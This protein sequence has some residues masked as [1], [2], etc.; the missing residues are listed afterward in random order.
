M[1]SVRQSIIS[2]EPSESSHLLGTESFGSRYTNE[3]YRP[4]TPAEGIIQ[5]EWY[6]TLLSTLLE[7]WMNIRDTYDGPWRENFIRKLKAIVRCF[8]LPCCLLTRALNGRRRYFEPQTGVIYLY[9]YLGVTVVLNLVVALKIKNKNEISLAEYI[10]KYFVIFS[11]F[12][13]LILKFYLVVYRYETVTFKNSRGTILRFFNEGGTFI[14]G[15]FCFGYSVC[16]VIDYVSCGHALD[17]LVQVMKAIFTVLQ[18]LFLHFFYEAR[19]PEDSPY[20]QIILAHLLGTNLGIWFWT[21]C[22]DEAGKIL[23]AESCRDYPI[24]LENMDEYFA[25]LFVEYLLLAASLFYQIW[26]DLLPQFT[27]VSLPQRHCSTCSCTSMTENANNQSETEDGNANSVIASAAT[28]TRSRSHNSSSG[29]RSSGLGIF[30]GGVFAVLFI[31]LVVMSK[32]TGAKHQAYHKVY[33]AGT[34]IFYFFQI[35]ACYIC[36]LSLQSHQRNPDRVSLNH[37]DI[38]LYIS[39]VGILLW[40]GFHSYT[41]ILSGFSHGSDVFDFAKDIL[42]ILQ[43]LFQTTTLVNIRRHKRTKGRCSVWICECVLFLM[44]TNFTL[45]VQDSFFFDVDITT[46]GERNIQM[47]HDLKSVGYIIY[48]LSTFFRFHSAVC[49]IIAWSIFRNVS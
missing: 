10:Q 15:F 35:C 38:L 21:L 25:I 45:W 30:V 32:A 16:L 33:S 11:M 14:F 41:L 48:P 1:A 29:Q 43:H 4:V 44:I 3:V 23:N 13:A 26:N 19:I 18:I 2:N 12:V 17:A 24:P 7:L 42:A 5:Q 9:L 47:Q 49:C 20:I 36:E 27:N 46:P 6:C 28:I 8:C 40:E 31:V 39:L 22:S 34:F 37:E